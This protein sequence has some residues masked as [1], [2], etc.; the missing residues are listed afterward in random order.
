MMRSRNDEEEVDRL[1]WTIYINQKRFTNGLGRR[2]DICNREKRH[3]AAAWGD[4]L[5]TT[6]ISRGTIADE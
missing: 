4:A 1:F 6:N 3:S 2:V 5:L